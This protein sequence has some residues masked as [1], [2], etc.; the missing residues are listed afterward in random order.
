MTYNQQIANTI[1]QQLGGR[2]FIIMTGARAFVATDNGVRFRIGRNA[3][4]TN[5]VRIT[6]RG[7]DTYNMEFLYVRNP[8]NPYTLLAKYIGMGMNPM[9]AERKVKE[10]TDHY[11]QVQ[12]LKEHKGIY[13]DQLAELFTEFTKLYTRLF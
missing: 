7:D 10:K 4:R 6:L 11:Q 2:Q 5:M 9:E 1:L 12:T 3:T 8:P 13:C